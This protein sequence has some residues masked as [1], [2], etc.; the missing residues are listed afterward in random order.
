MLKLKICGVKDA[1]NYKELIPLNPEFIGLNFYKKSPRYVGEEKRFLKNETTALTGVFVDE[2]VEIIQQIAKY[3]DLDYLQ[4]HG[5]ETADYC[6][7]LKDAGYKIIKVFRVGGDFD[8]TLLEPY[9]E[10]CHYFLFDTA[11][12]Q[13][14]GNGKVFN[15]ELLNYYPY[16]K[17][18]FLAGGLSPDN[19]HEVLQLDLPQLFAL[20]I[21]SGFEDEPGIKNIEKVKELKELLTTNDRN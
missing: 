20:D 4:L 7:Q 21:N 16:K 18:Y 1:L 12:R 9:L 2:G 10:Y 19:M 3:H 13:P 17:P 8:F 11:G 14:G 15:W 6:R 5:N